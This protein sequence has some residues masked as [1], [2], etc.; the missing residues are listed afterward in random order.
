MKRAIP[1]ALLCLA[2]GSFQ[3]CNCDDELDRCIV[4]T[5]IQTDEVAPAGV[6]TVFQAT[7]CNGDPIPD[8][9]DGDVTLLLDGQ[10]LQTEGDVAPVLT[11]AI[12]FEMYTL[13]LLDMSDSIVQSGNLLAMVNAART[14]VNTLV[15]QGHKVAI[16]RFAGPA[17]FGVVQDFTTS[18]TDLDAALDGLAASQGLGTTDLYGS[19]VKALLAL[20]GA[21][22]P[23]VLHTKTLV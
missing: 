23:E 14:L 6:R 1:F 11:Q 9:T 8:L 20:D 13:L 3:S 4:L 5:E 12:E 15:G 19:I 17:Y 2:L 7:D 16:F 22:N 10:E 21:P 18:E